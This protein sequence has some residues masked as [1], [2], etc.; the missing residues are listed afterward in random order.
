M[1]ASLA[2]PTTRPSWADDDDD[3]ETRDAVDAVVDTASINASVGSTGRDS[4]GPRFRVSYTVHTTTYAKTL[5]DV[6]GNLLV[7]ERNVPVNVF[8]R[9]MKEM[10]DRGDLI[11]FHAPGKPGHRYF[12]THKQQGEEFRK[13][14]RTGF[15]SNPNSFHVYE[16][17]P[18]L[19]LPFEG[20]YPTSY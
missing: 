19:V 18:G 10:M 15:S 13:A 8:K 6:D 17:E 20:K 4:F 3:D 16:D 5:Y 2:I 14:K 11:C 9:E 1:A 7:D 12:V